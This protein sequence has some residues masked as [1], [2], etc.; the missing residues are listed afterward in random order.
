[1]ET[2]YLYDA[3]LIRVVDGDTIEVNID[4]GFDVSINT[5]VR[6]LG[7]DTPEIR[8]NN[9]DEKKRGIEAKKFVEEMFKKN[10]NKCIVHSYKNTKEKYGRY[11]ARILFNDRCLNDILLENKHIK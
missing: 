8:T 5:M 3:K 9:L 11:L 4:L 10:E 7:V 2:N 1:M 6:L